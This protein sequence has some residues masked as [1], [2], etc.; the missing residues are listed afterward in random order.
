MTTPR[1]PRNGPLVL[2][3]AL[4]LVLLAAGTTYWAATRDDGGEPAREAEGPVDDPRRI[5]LAGDSMTQG[6]NGDRTWRYHLWNHLSPQVEGLDF[7][8][9][10]TDPAT[11]DMILPVPTT[12]DEAV[13]TP[14]GDPAEGYD[15]GGAPD[16]APADRP[17][18][19]SSGLSQQELEELEDTVWP[20]ADGDPHTVEYRDPDFD[21]NH[22]ALWGRTLRDAA[23][24][25]QE[26][27]RVH[28]PDVLCVMLG[29]ND[30]LWPVTMEEMEYRLRHYA[31]SARAA[32]PNLRIVIAE[33]LPIALAESD[34]GFA[35][36]VYAYNELVREVAADLSTDA[37]PVISLDVAGR[38]GWDVSADTYDGTHPNAGG[39]TKIAAAFADALAQGYGI[40]FGFPRPLAVRPPAG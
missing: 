13:E 32:N 23:A 4:A 5:M 12:G 17:S 33:A 25:I 8:G 10:Y 20:G 11:R 27:V 3:G 14:E 34:E 7:V 29:V 2:A 24:S 6:A 39:E 37:S 1:R 21:Q 22:N 35:L 30:L 9:P 31:E 28:R 18:G 19:E 38:E 36:R 15:E 26:E 16:G 40:G